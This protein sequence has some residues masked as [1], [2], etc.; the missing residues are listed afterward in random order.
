VAVRG[1][2]GARKRHPIQVVARRTGLS[3]D[4]LRAWEKR[5][6]VVEPERS[7]GGRRL[8]S[9]EDIERLRLLRRATRS[10][11]R[12]G[13]VAALKIEELA[14]IVRE[15]ERQAAEAEPEAAL[16][17]L[18]A[19]DAYLTAALG[20]V[21]RLESRELEALLNRALVTLNAAT[22]I[23][24]VAGPLM[25]RLG[26]LWG[27]GELQPAHEH[28]ASVVL[29]RVLGRVIR[30]AEPVGAAPNVVVATPVGQRHE[31]GAL[32]AA[33]AA[34]FEGW[35]VTYLGPDLP[36][37]D[38]AIAARETGAE[39]AALSLVHPEGD[40]DLVEDLKELRLALPPAVPILVGGP[41]TPSYR[42]VLNEIEAIQLADLAELRAALSD[43]C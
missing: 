20:A 24:K 10:G 26:E 22:V 7:S 39:A 14:A 8:Y 34:A 33:A 35:R 5:Y 27:A 31:F 23:E 37:Q 16:G 4:V 29:R 6:G 28:L 32:F 13:Q 36:A 17:E 30:S 40:P 2:E 18:G 9:D 19:A 41:A 15:D 12:I 21:E 38:I 1:F 11:R 3:P 43:L 42:E 25:R